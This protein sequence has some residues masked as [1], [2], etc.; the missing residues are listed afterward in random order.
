MFAL[1]SRSTSAAP[2]ATVNGRYAVRLFQES[3]RITI[4]PAIPAVLALASV[5]T[6]TLP[7]WPLTLNWPP[8]MLTLA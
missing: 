4:P 6:A 2:S 7:N 3:P 8:V 1:T 5:L